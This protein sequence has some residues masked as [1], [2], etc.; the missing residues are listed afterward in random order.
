MPPLRTTGPH[1]FCAPPDEGRVTLDGDDAHHLRT[2]LRAG[3][4]APVSL[5][6][7][8][9][10]L[11]QAT[12]TGFAGAAVR[13]EVTAAATVPA[14]RP[15]VTVV[16][17]LP[18][19]RKADEVVQRLTELGVDR[20]VAVHS[21]RSQ[22][23]LDPAR[24]AKAQ[25]R[26]EAVALAA[27]KQSRRA[28][29]LLVEPVGEWPGPPATAGAV[30]WEE[31]DRPLRE[32][33]APADGVDEITLLVGPEGGLTPDEVAATGLPAASLGPTILRTETAAI[34]AAALVLHAV[35][36]LG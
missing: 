36:R 6:D 8:A 17:A 22:V 2:V 14:P 12:V 7:G 21:S 19:G 28:R 35:G 11:Y 31:A 4:G 10:G 23:A 18:K 5:A 16:Q 3:P 33:L 20:Y 9:G 24:A 32:V 1:F 15:V 26:W 29:P 25:R 27:A 30:L 13:L 34:A